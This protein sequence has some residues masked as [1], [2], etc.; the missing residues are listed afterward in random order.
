MKSRTNGN[1]DPTGKLA[2]DFKKS[3]HMDNSTPILLSVHCFAGKPVLLKPLPER[4]YIRKAN[5]EKVRPHTY[6][7][8]FDAPLNGLVQ[9]FVYFPKVEGPFTVVLD[10]EQNSDLVFEFPGDRENRIRK[11]AAQKARMDSGLSSAKPENSVEQSGSQKSSEAEWKQESE[12]LNKRIRDLVAERDLLRGELDKVLAE[13]AR[14]ENLQAKEIPQ[15]QPSVQ[16]AQ[17][18]QPVQTVQA[19]QPLPSIADE[20]PAVTSGLSREI[21]GE[22]FL[23]AWKNGDI[24]GMYRCLSPELRSRMPDENALKEFMKG[25]ILPDRMPKDA[26]AVVKGDGGELKVEFATKILFV[27]TLRAVRIDLVEGPG[28]W[29]VGQIE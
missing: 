21:V 4:L 26:K 19:A 5:G 10:T 28:G 12:R 11:E 7:S 23:E 15:P 22:V 8:V 9:G 24:S 27:R 16:P 14:E 3:L 29:F 6:D 25:K 18:I 17:P 13:T 20:Y 1:G 2:R